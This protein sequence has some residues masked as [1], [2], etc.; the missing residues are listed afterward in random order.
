MDELLRARPDVVSVETG[1]T[2]EL[3]PALAELEQRELDVLVLNGGDGTV[4]CAL[5]ELLRDPHRDRLPWVAR[6]RGGRTNS[7]SADLGADR[8][9]A[10]GLARLIEAAEAGRLD[11]LAV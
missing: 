4:Q 8:D 7:T 2:H 9:P 5:T 10:R 1:G 6:L 3:G 11:A